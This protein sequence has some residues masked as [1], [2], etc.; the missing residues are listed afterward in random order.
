M[1]TT[2]LSL[3][4]PILARYSARQGDTLILTLMG[5]GGYRL[6]GQVL[7][8]IF[9]LRRKNLLKRDNISS[10][11]A[12]SQ[13]PLVTHLPRRT[14]LTI[15]FQFE[16]WMP[17]AIQFRP[18]SIIVH[19]HHVKSRIPMAIAVRPRLTNLVSWLDLRAWERFQR[20]LEI[21]SRDSMHS[22]R[23]KT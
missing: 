2:A 20:M 1:T 18:R 23:K 21:H 9:A 12:G 15:S 19:W 7:R 17:W 8:R 13:I 10:L 5:T 16:M 6:E 3:L 4:L 14:T 11:P 22:S